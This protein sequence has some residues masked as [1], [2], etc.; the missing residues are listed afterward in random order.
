MKYL[1]GAEKKQAINWI[2]YAAELARE[3]AVCHRSKCGAVIVNTNDRSIGVGYNAPPDKNSIEKCIKDSLPA[4]FK[5]E[6]HC[7]VHAEQMAIMDALER[8]PSELAG[9]TLYF[10]RLDAKGNKT[11]AGK[12]YCTICSKMA[13]RAKISEF[14]LWHKEG[15][16]VYNTEEYNKLSF[17]FKG[18]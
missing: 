2:N 18:D 15:I 8:N 17:Q 16:C 1:S 13:L 5:S 7:C 6:K 9:S 4:D 12:P 11:P 3:Y 14:V 10:I